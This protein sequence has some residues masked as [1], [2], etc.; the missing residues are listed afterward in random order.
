M[1]KPQTARKWA[2]K[3]KIAQNKSKSKNK[4]A[5]C[6]VGIIYIKD[7]EKKQQIEEAD[8]KKEGKEEDTI[9]CE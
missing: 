9:V 3:I 2:V 1:K 8:K 4:L 7:N 6:V 5:I